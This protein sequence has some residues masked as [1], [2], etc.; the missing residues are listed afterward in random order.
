MKSYVVDSSVV[1]KW[2]LPEPESKRAQLLIKT[3][4]LLRAPDLIMPEFASVLLK[5]IVRKEMT[6]HECADLL[7]RFLNEYLDVRV[8]LV[9]SRLLALKALEIAR[10]E[11]RSIYDSLYLALAVQAQCQLITADEKLVNAITDRQLKKHLIALSDPA[12]EV[13]PQP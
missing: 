5:R 13:E 10:E 6:A 9:P 11:R 1:A 7:S 4:Y 3:D 2:L 8:H 12:L